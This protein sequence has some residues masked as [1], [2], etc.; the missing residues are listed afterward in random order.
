M[1]FSFL[2]IQRLGQFPVVSTMVCNERFT[3]NYFQ[4]T[5]NLMFFKKDTGFIVLIKKIFHRKNINTS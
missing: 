4:R 1:H 3:I 5:V 2:T